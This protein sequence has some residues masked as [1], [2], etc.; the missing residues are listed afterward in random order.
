MVGVV[1][2]GDVGDVFSFVVVELFEYEGE[3]VGVLGEEGGVGVVVVFGF[4][5]GFGK[6]RDEG[7][8]VFL[9]VCS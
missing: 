5:E 9:L 8:E 7:V 1:L 2:G 3:G 6:E 4:F